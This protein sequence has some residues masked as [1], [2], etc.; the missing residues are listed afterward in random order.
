MVKISDPGQDMT[1]K[2]GDKFHLGRLIY[3][4]PGNRLCLKN[5]YALLLQRLNLGVVREL[6]S[7]NR[8]RDPQIG[9]TSHPLWDKL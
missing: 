5:L 2:G 8:R 7:P 3:G 1:R 9:T 6:G 4:V